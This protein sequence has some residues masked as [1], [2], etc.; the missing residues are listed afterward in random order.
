M[1]IAWDIARYQPP[2]LDRHLD[3][4]GIVFSPAD[5]P[6]DGAGIAQL[7]QFELGHA[8]GGAAGGGIAA[9][10]AGGGA[11]SGS[12]TAAV[13]PG[14]D[15]STG[16]VSVAGGTGLVSIDLSAGGGSFADFGI[17][18]GDRRRPRYARRRTPRL[19]PTRGRGRS[20]PA[21]SRGGT[22][23]AARIGLIRPTRI[24]AA[25]PRSAPGQAASGRR[26]SQA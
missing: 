9:S 19:A 17:F 21:P 11:I 23:G 1:P 10:V 8:Q 3:L 7:G 4:D 24:A 20:R 25:G 15:V 2:V 26:R 5:A 12:L 22:A 6:V 13:G 16:S 18:G 14:G